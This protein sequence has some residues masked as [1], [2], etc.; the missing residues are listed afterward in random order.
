MR[1][2]RLLPALVLALLTGCG[3]SSVN[4][5]SDASTTALPKII[6]QTDWYA[7]PEHG[8]FYQAQLSGYYEEAGLDV[9]IR[10]GAN[11]NNVPQMVATN[12]IQFAVGTSDNLIMAISR[13]I[14]LL[15]LF[16]YFQHD[17]Q[18]VMFHKESGIETLADLDGRTVMLNPG[19]AYVQYLQKTLGIKLQLVPLDYSLTRF[20]ADP[21]FVQQCF[22]TSEPFFVAQQGV[23]AGVLPL[24]SSGFDPYRIV[25]TN[26][27]FAAQNP[28]LVQAFLD[29][30]ARGWM[31]Y[32]E[33]D[34]SAVHERLAALNPQQTPEFMTFT[35]QALTD[36]NLIEGTAGE[37]FGRFD[38][39]RLVTHIGHLEALDLLDSTVEVDRAFGFDYLPERFRP[40]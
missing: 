5:S 29:A 30:S 17:P 20:L 19:A 13:G 28:E 37:A 21:T 27:E 23:E 33:G 38:R 9:E 22:V 32:I 34:G 36:N 15:A 6:L 8:G 4:D 11:I 18:C 25:Y 39:E 35:K 14:P 3:D 1:I 16:P 24:S 26:A 2:R 40:E 12:R 31:T 7:Q 10:P